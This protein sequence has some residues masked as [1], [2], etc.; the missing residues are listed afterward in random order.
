MRVRARGGGATTLTVLLDHDAT[1]EQK[2][3]AEQ[4]LRGTP[5]AG[6]VTRR[7]REQA[8]DQLRK[9]SPDLAA[10]VD[11]TTMPESLRTTL[12][13]PSVAEA[14]ELTM[15]AVD[16]VA[17]SV[18][19]AAAA[20]PLPSAIGM[21]VRLEP[22]IT[23]KQRATVEETVRALPK[24]ESVRFE[25]RD[26]AYDRLREQCRGKG[27]LAGRLETDMTRPSLRLKL[28]LAHQGGINPPEIA[29][30]DGVEDVLL[31]PTA[32]L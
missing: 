13:D 10:Q 24:A 18:L 29:R 25:D 3:T 32:V 26:A 6:D 20:D 9:D 11:P 12:T 31:V 2:A 28:P 17:S 7:T 22:S 14:A 23:E 4:I 19:T 30:M 5:S 21:I 16:G 8:Y 1:A 15:V 27:D